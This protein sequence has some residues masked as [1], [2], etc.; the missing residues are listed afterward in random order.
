M[1]Q[2]SIKK[3]KKKRKKMKVKKSFLEKYRPK[4]EEDVVGNF[5]IKERVLN[6]LKEG[7][8]PNM[9]FTGNAG[10]GKTSLADIA[11][12]KVLGENY[13]RDRVIFNCSDKTGIDN[14]R[15]NVIQVAKMKPSGDIRI[16]HM[17]ESEQLSSSA[18]KALKK[19]LEA[20]YDKSNRFIFLSNDI[21]KFIDP[22]VDRCR[23]YYFTPIRPKEM[24]GRLR[25]VSNEE[26]IDISDELLM[27][28]AELSN[29]SM[30]YPMIILEELST[31]NREIESEDLK[32]REE[33]SEIQN[34]FMLL[35]GKKIPKAKDSVYKLYENGNNFSDVIKGFHDFTIMSIENELNFKEKAKCLIKIAETERN[36]KNGCN[37]FIQFSYLLSNISLLLQNT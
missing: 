19:V 33:L 5:R 30:R 21:S 27:R 18:Q 9:I 7:K 20:P 29:G 25:F 35:K 23:V 6:Q 28:L 10:I 31:L 11:E 3:E 24:F 2:K 32:L 22:I 13:Y 36:V 4:T 26:N 1:L 8:I 37:E 14:I 17:E 34:I 16:F 15:K 12:R